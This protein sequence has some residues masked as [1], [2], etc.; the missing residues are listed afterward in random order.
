MKIDHHFISI[1]LIVLFLFSFVYYLYFN[2]NK[3]I[4]YQTIKNFEKQDADFT[5][6]DK[7]FK[8]KTCDDYCSRDVCT[9]YETELNN[10]KKCLTCQKNLKC[11]NPLTN[12]C[13]FCFSFGINQC[14]SPLNPK[15]NL[16][17]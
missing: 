1:I 2:K 10:Y 7:L 12:Q 4:G 17:K 15:N 8:R 3:I 14:K 16:C 5:E 13:E 9:K 6:L 11:F